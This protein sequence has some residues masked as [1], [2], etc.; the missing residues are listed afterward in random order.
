M[1]T[2]FSK[3]GTKIAYDAQGSGP[4]LI[5]I[6]GAMTKRLDNEKPEL[7][8]LLA[9]YYKVYCY[10]RRGRGDSGDTQPYAVQREVEDIEA[11]IDQSGGSAFLY[12][13]SSGA[14]LGLEAALALEGKVR[15]LAIYEAPYND[16]PE[17]RLAWK[18][19]IR[20]LTDL[21]AA[22]RHGDAIALFM[23]L[24]GTPAEQ[25]EGMRQAPFWKSLEA[26][27]P[28]LAYDHT[29]LMGGEAAIPLEKFANVKTPVLVMVGGASFPFM[30]ISAQ[31]LS[32]A[33]P[34]AKLKI[35]EGQT[36]NVSSQVLAPALV[37]FFGLSG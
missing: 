31:S 37:E 36:H 4:G 9:Q 2:V 16:A 11:L 32:L 22:G 7:A 24:V 8:S 6:D 14:V 29:A 12:G 30:H 21:L 15:K 27:A 23:R 26:L 17:A 13:H 19:Y 33:I 35:L 1:D 20:D 18:N 10:D 28:T 25:V 34:G 3:D 5:L